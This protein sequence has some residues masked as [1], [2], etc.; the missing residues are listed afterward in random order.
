MNRPGPALALFDGTFLR[1]FKRYNLKLLENLVTNSEIAVP[2]F[3]SK[4]FISFKVIA[5][6]E[7][8]L[9]LHFFILFCVNFKNHLVLT[10]FN[11]FT[12]KNVARAIRIIQGLTW[13]NVF[14]RYK[15]TFLGQIKP[16]SPGFFCKSG[17]GRFGMADSVRLS[18]NLNS[19][20]RNKRDIRC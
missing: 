8:P 7:N 6:L 2:S 3:E 14:I 17:R 12:W 5:F 19:I 18:L 1:K 15:I 9:F 10:K 13:K 16:F 4:M 11:S 20:L